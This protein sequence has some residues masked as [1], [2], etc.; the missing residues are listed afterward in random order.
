MAKIAFYRFDPDT[1]DEVPIRVLEADDEATIE[2]YRDWSN[3][4]LLSRVADEKNPSP[5]VAGTG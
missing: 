3:G 4:Y 2:F 5:D 1:M